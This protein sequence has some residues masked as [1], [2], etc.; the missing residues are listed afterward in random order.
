MTDQNQ[1]D[2]TQ[3]IVPP[4][5]DKP[6]A[7]P[8]PA[9]EKPSAEEMAAAE[10]R[11]KKLLKETPTKKEA[12]PVIEDGGSG[13]MLPKR[14][15]GTTVKALLILLV[16]GIAGVGIYFG[17]Q[18]TTNLASTDPTSLA[19][20]SKE[21]WR[22]TQTCEGIEVTV[23][24]DHDG[25][26]I[27]ADFDNTGHCEGVG[28]WEAK[29][30]LGSISSGDRGPS[31]LAWNPLPDRNAY[32]CVRAGVKVGRESFAVF[33]EPLLECGGGR[34][35]ECRENACV[36]VDGEGDNQCST[37]DD[38]AGDVLSCSSLTRSPAAELSLGEVVTL[39][40]QSETEKSIDHFEF[41]YTTDGGV[42][43]TSLAAGAANTAE[44][45]VLGTSVL[46]IAETGDY[47]VQCRVCEDAAGTACTIWGMNK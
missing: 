6:L 5:D 27:W 41:R 14:G 8:M 16:L 37:N 39:S 1:N 7:A 44:G 35:L 47:S 28:K 3:N 30:T 12:P 20:G 33:E 25:Y 40:C 26:Q 23:R 9:A 15:M 13:D 36:E 24:H 4:P 17:I 46:T 42:N 29:Q 43:Y 38:C 32:N 18:R 22:L 45:V 2:P 31:S 11:A 34:H 21:G 19:A 10:E